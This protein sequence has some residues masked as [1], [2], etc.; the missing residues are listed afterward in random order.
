MPI[1]LRDGLLNIDELRAKFWQEVATHLRQRGVEPG[2][3]SDDTAAFRGRM[4]ASGA[5]ETIY[6]WEPAEIAES[7]HRGGF[8]RSPDLPH[9]RDQIGA[10]ERPLSRRR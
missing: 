4:E 9:D 10:R 1:P 6:P 3:A 7:I 5:T 2:K 8:G